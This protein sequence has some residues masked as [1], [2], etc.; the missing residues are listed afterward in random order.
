[1]GLLFVG[2][3]MNIYWITGLALYVLI[4]KAVPY[5]HAISRMVGV[6]LAAWGVALIAGLA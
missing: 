5:G 6:A 3:I 1:M 2:G 4:E